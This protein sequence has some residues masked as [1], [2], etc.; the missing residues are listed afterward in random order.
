MS[1]K[2]SRDLDLV[3]TSAKMDC[4]MDAELREVKTFGKVVSFMEV[5]SSSMRQ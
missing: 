1:I 3:R 5:S 4:F 2:N